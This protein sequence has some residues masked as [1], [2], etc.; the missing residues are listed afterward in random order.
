MDI[1]YGIV[2]QHGTDHQN[3]NVE[4][5]VEQNHRNVP[6]FIIE[7]SIV[8]KK[9]L[10]SFVDHMSTGNTKAPDSFDANAGDDPKCHRDYWIENIPHGNINRCYFLNGDHETEGGGGVS[11]LNNEYRQNEDSNIYS[12]KPYQC[13]GE[14]G[15]LAGTGA[16]PYSG[17][18]QLSNSDRCEDDLMQFY[19]WDKL[20]AGSTT[21]CGTWNTNEPLCAEGTI[22]IIDSKSYVWRDSIIQYETDSICGSPQAN[23]DLNL[24]YNSYCVVDGS[25]TE[26]T[27]P[28]GFFMDRTCTGEETTNEDY[29]KW[30][31]DVDE[32]IKN[33][34]LNGIMRVSD[35]GK[36]PMPILEIDQQ[37][38]DLLSN[39]D[40]M[41]LI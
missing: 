38:E 27:C 21:Y 22:S 41:K 7:K 31:V 13:I 33:G 5:C 10:T 35:D 30:V 19:S 28:S 37:W 18:T 34:L 26:C 2:I 36:S 25:C 40:N 8:M 24:L 23:E 1:C 6:D 16:N 4:K 12:S 11:L 20:N 17:M 15:V 14:T 9:W 32:T 3:L 29:Q 39:S